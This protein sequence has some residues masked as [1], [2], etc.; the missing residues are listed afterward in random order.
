MTCP[1]GHTALEFLAEWCGM[2]CKV[3][4]KVYSYAELKSRE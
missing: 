4:D 3:C 2:L 1:K